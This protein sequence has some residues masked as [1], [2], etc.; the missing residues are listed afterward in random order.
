MNYSAID[1]QPFET[2]PDRHRY[3]RVHRST[4]IQTRGI[5][6]ATR[7]C[8]RPDVDRAHLGCL[9]TRVRVGREDVGQEFGIPADVIDD[10][11]DAMC[12]RSRLHGVTFRLRPSLRDASDEF[13]L[14]LAVACGATSW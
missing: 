14:E 6:P 13:V 11:V 12:A 1:G 4:E 2:V 3:I 5:V 7:N 9:G 10:L 8:W